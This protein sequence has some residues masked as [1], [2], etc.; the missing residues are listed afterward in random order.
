MRKQYPHWIWFV[1]TGG[2]LFTRLFRL[3]ILDKLQ[4]PDDR[5]KLQG[6]D[7]RFRLPLRLCNICSTN[8]GRSTVKE[9]LCR[10]D[11]YNQLLTK[12]PHS[13][14]AIGKG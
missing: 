13:E 4:E 5:I 10:V 12:Y 2:L 9:M 7:V 6:R 8:L 11:V 3:M 1:L 14:I